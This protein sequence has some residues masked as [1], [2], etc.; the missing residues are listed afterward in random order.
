MDDI[1]KSLAR[2]IA[3]D[4]AIRAL[5][6]RYPPKKY[7]VKYPRDTTTRNI[8]HVNEMERRTYILEYAR[9]GL[10]EEVLPLIH[11]SGL[12]IEEVRAIMALIYG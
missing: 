4:A 7:P 6:A 3:F 2:H 12:P 10:P 1:E 8:Y 11:Q 5:S 9:L